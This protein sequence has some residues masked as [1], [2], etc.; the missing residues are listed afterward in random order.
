MF[1]KRL[2]FKKS[3]V[4]LLI[5]FSNLSKAPVNHIKDCREREM[6]VEKQTGGGL[7]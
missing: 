6:G 4:A 7:E 5:K 2:L 3:T 1:V